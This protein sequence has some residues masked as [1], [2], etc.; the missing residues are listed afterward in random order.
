MAE[1]F[2]AP[3]SS[4]V[5]AKDEALHS[6]QASLRPEAY[7]ALCRLR[8]A[9]QSESEILEKALVLLDTYT[10]VSKALGRQNTA[11]KAVN[12]VQQMR[13]AGYADDWAL[14]LCRA[15][16]RQRERD[17]RK[18][19]QLFDQD[20]S[21]WI[22]SSELRQALPLMGEEVPESKVDALFELVDKDN[23]GLLDFE[24]FCFLVKGLNSEEGSEEHDAFASFKSSAE[25][26]LEAV[27]GAVGSMASGTGK[28]L[29]AVSTAW[30]ANLQGLSPFEMRK[31]GAI[32]NNMV[33]AGYSENMA[34]AICRALFCG[35][36]EKQLQKAY[37]F[38]D[39]D[40]NG[41][42]DVSELKQAL[43]LMAEDVSEEDVVEIFQAVDHDGNGAV[44]FEEFCVLV[45]AVK[46]KGDKSE[47]GLL[48]AV[49][50]TWEKF[51]SGFGGSTASQ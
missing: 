40:E 19:F 43:K 48:S 6:V 27:G 7:H 17:L 11:V 42:I 50:T 12:V 39:S 10:V 13:S 32:L 29:S 22:E 3:S 9:D 31:A 34:I 38:F 37:K 41:R 51:S 24:E 28:A 14:I 30:S 26:T 21:S 16:F 15:L 46:D 44:S 5:Q 45:K 23:Q 18:A 4:A 33:A 36:T 1:E 49:T 20:G 8:R 2:L 47:T 25:G 35:Q